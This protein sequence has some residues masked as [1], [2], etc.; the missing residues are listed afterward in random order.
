MGGNAVLKKHSGARFAAP[1]LEA[2]WLEDNDRLLTEYPQYEHSDQVLYQKSRA[3]DELGR[4]EEAMA[5]MEQL[6]R[7]S[8]HS[9][10][11]DEVQFRRGEYFFMPS[12]SALRWIGSL[13][14]T[15]P[16]KQ[17]ER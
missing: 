10:H 17:K 13:A 6:I 14:E 5:T 12:L 7:V 16:T 2:G 8:P 3:Y 11:L 9:E 4:T 15:N 1:A